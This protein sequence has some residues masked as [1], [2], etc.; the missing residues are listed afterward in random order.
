MAIKSENPFYI[1]NTKKDMK[2]LQTRKYS[3]KEIDKAML[4]IHP[5]SDKYNIRPDLANIFEEWSNFTRL[6]NP[7]VDYLGNEFYD[8]EAYYLS[9]RVKN[10]EQDIYIQKLLSEISN[11]PIIK[12]S[13]EY[14]KIRQKYALDQDK[15]NRIIYMQ[16]AI[17]QKFD[18]NP[19]LQTKLIESWDKNIIEYT[20]RGDV[21]FGI[22]QHS[23]QWANILWKLLVEYRNQVRKSLLYT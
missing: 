16:K 17:K 23:L 13:K 10:Y 18:K 5:K 19:N 6:E 12:K 15:N 22:D 20:Y 14:N 1:Y 8:S 21:L 11:S 3:K 7:I 2:I 4:I 9:Q